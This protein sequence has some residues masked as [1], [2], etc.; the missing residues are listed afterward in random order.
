MPAREGLTVAPRPT[1]KRDHAGVGEILKSP[2]AAAIVNALAH[3]IA[4][5]AGPEAQVDEYTTD[6]RAAS[7]SL[8]AHLQTR[9]GALTRAAAA[10]GL[11][12]RSS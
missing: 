5:K 1:F 11:E 7:V 6:R 2:E 3:Q 4:A 9:S 10:V 8:P 12:V